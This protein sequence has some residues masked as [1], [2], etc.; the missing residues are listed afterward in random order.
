ME[1]TSSNSMHKPGFEDA[2]MEMHFS[3][4]VLIANTAV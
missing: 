2:A 4:A 1:G 3:Q